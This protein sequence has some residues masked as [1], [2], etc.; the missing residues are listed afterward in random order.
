M[1]DTEE[2]E[3]DHTEG[4]TQH[5]KEMMNSVKSAGVHAVQGIKSNVNDIIAK[6]AHP[7]ACLF[8]VLFKVC[9]VVAYVLFGLVTNDNVFIYI[10]VISL[11]AFDFWTVKNVTGR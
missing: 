1:H 6:S 9:A 4:K 10:M 8:H 3:E 2:M 7:V 11:C 5:G